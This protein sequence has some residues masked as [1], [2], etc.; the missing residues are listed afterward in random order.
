[1]TNS[2]TDQVGSGFKTQMINKIIYTY[3]CVNTGN[4]NVQVISEERQELNSTTNASNI[5]AYTNMIRN[6]EN[7]YQ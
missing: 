5:P 1:M 4:P 7:I 2:L 3:N 6:I